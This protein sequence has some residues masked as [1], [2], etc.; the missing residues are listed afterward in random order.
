MRK[1]RTDR[2]KRRS[3]TFWF[4]NKDSAFEKPATAQLAINALYA[5]SWKLLPIVFVEEG[6][7]T[8]FFR[9]PRGVA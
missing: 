9:R 1:C 8:S 2:W 4:E 7:T 5:E 3:T 6:V